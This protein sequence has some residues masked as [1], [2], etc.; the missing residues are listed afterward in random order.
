MR[1]ASSP[2]WHLRKIPA[3]SGLSR[4]ALSALASAARLCQRSRGVILH[5]P[6]DDSDWV[7]ILH[8]G[9]ISSLHE[10][11]ACRTICLGC[12]GP[13]DIFGESGLWHPAPRDD[14]AVVATPALLSV[15]PRVALRLLLDEHPEIERALF[16]QWIARRDASLR[17]LRDALGL[18]VRARLAAQLLELAEHGQDTPEGRALGLPIRQHELAAL[19]VTTRE[20]VT[21]ELARLE[22][23]RL[24]SRQGR[25]IVLRDLARLRIAAR[26]EVE[27]P[28]PAVKPRSPA[29]P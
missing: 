7:Y 29:R 27:P 20:T 3:F 19:V 26:D 23:D 14:K 2:V 15:V 1:P 10:A 4:E 11:S 8:G 18:S 9:R 5:N 25:Q 17:R 24:I 22:H 28:N 21:V 16:M 13:G 6:G 12:F